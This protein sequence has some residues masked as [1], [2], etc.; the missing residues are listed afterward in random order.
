MKWE[1]NRSKCALLVIDMQNDFVLPGA[2][3]EVPRAKEQLPKI[4]Q[5]I[6]ACRELNMPVVYT[7]HE[8]HPDYCALEIAAFPHLKE[9]GMRRGT[10]GAEVVDALSPLANEVVIRKRRFSAFYQTE[11]ELILRGMGV[12][13]LIICGTVTNICCESTARDAFFRDFKVVFGNDICSAL[14]EKTH[15]ATL[16]N[17]EI[18]GE[19]MR[20]DE[21]MQNLRR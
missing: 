21:I 20:L 8:T 9:A 6:E 4:A 12:D 5:L 7:V 13:T 16:A 15:N 2:I 3:M 1:F 10:P 18:F 19:V 14:D 11:L 17:M